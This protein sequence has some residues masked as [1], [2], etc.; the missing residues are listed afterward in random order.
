M[1]LA[2][3]IVAVHLAIVLF[4]LFG[5]ILILIGWPLRWGWIRNRWFRF[6]HLFVI[7]W[8]AVQAMLGEMCPLTTWERRLR[9][10]SLDEGQAE[11]F[12]G[13]LLHDILFVDVPLATLNRIYI[14]FGVTVVLCALLCPPRR[15]TKIA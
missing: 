5:Q 15:K 12:V 9:E 10:T 14:G 3:V 4:A 1:L 8:V 6:S 13:Q 7:A 2:D 11:S